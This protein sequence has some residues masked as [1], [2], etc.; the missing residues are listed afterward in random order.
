LLVAI[1]FIPASVHAS[2]VCIVYF[3]SASCGEDCVITDSFVNGLMKEYSE[4]L[5]AIKYYVDS[6]Q[7]NMDVFE[8]Y[9]TKYNLPSS[10]PLVL[11]GENNYLLGRNN[12]FKNI[13]AK[14][15]GFVNANGTNC[16]LESGY[17]PPSELV[18]I[19]LPGS[20][21]IFE[22]DRET[23]DDIVTD[24]TEPT[25][26]EVEITAIEYLTNPEI[27]PVLVSVAAVVVLVAAIVL[28]FKK[29]SRGR[30]RDVHGMG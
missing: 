29:R 3:T 13:E 21:E 16:P 5:T 1:L 15:Y 18:Q 27:F 26:R 8:T 6:S 9:R 20:P 12:I 30:G 7:E 17:L 19:V 2:E 23:E 25:D 24:D 11:F 14:I 22:R 10:I 4:T 28:I